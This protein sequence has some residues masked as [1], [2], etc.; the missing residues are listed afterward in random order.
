MWCKSD[1][2]NHIQRSGE[3]GEQAGDSNWEMQMKV[4]QTS[5][6]AETGRQSYKR[7][8]KCNLKKGPKLVLDSLMV[9]YLNQD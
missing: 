8:K 6:E 2:R 7:N 9:D 3:K 1:P 5:P 4:R